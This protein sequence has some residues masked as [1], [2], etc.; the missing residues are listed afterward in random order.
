[1][2]FH[3]KNDD[4]DGNRLKTTFYYIERS[5]N[6]VFTVG[7]VLF[8]KWLENFYGGNYLEKIF[9]ARTP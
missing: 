4:L 7:A 9:K 5:E 8:L 6:D 1:M 3:M 2:K